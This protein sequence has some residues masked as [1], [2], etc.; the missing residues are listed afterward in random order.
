MDYFIGLVIALVSIALLARP[1]LRGRYIT[2][3]S[4]AS[5]NSI[6]DLEW[7]YH[8]IHDDIKTTILDHQIGNISLDEYHK[9]LE[10]YRLQAAYLLSKHHGML[11]ETDHIDNEIEN[12]VLALRVSWGTV[13]T[14]T[15][16]NEC[17]EDMD[18]NAIL[19]PRC[20]GTAT[21]N[22]NAVEDYSVED[23]NS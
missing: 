21:Q 12:E 23:E 19:C 13:K 1:I 18:I 5:S 15:T 7:Q 8:Q 10:A 20:E 4:R 17:T 16:C 14:V 11:L 22:T 3:M 6:Q 9:R 2:P